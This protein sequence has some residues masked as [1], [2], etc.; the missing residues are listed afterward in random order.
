ML[1]SFSARFNRWRVG[2]Q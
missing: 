2:Q 1:F